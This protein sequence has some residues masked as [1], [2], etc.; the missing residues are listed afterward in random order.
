MV[1]LQFDHLVHFLDKPEDFITE[2]KE[3]SI[4]AVDGGVNEGRVTL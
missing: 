2:L 1:Q 3:Q 4:H